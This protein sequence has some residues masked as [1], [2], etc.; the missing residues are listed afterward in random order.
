MR[1]IFFDQDIIFHVL[2]SSFPFDTFLLHLFSDMRL[3][4]LVAM[5]T[6]SLNFFKQFSVNSILCYIWRINLISTWYSFQRND[7]VFLV[8]F[9]SLQKSFGEIYSFLLSVEIIHEILMKSLNLIQ[10]A[11]LYKLID[12]LISNSLPWVIVDCPNFPHFLLYWVLASFCGIIEIL[13]FFWD[14]KILWN[15]WLENVR[16]TEESLLIFSEGDVNTW[17]VP[18]LIP[19]QDT[20]DLFLIDRYLDSSFVSAGFALLIKLKCESFSHQW[21]H[22]FDISIYNS[23]LPINLWK[24]I[25]V[26]QMLLYYHWG[27]NLCADCVSQIEFFSAT[28]ATL[29]LQ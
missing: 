24:L 27:L 11:N 14:V 3:F 20:K 6:Y 4:L 5:D 7:I 16:V 28:L 25:L 29:F 1:F 18:N 19:C 17:D 13:G 9:S 8:H 15:Q 21:Y 12:L 23:L 10:C 26:D 22:S 2:K